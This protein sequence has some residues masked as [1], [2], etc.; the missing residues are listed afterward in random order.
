MN[1]LLLALIVSLTAFM[2]IGTVVLVWDTIVQWKRET[3]IQ[4]QWKRDT[5]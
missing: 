2:A 4:K 1:Y 3:K 5:F